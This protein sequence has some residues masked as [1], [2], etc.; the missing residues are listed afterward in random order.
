M[1]SPRNTYRITTLNRIH[2]MLCREYPNT[3]V[4][5]INEILIRCYCL[6]SQRPHKP[7]EVLNMGRRLAANWQE[8][9]A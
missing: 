6:L 1:Q 8:A 9:A 2:F 4:V 5:T 7:L 3:A